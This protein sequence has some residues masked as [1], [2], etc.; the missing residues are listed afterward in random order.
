M[1]AIFPSDVK[2][3][4]ISTPSDPHLQ[5]SSKAGIVFWGAIAEAPLWAMIFIETPLVVNKKIY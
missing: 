4:S 5:P 2:C 3:K 1:T